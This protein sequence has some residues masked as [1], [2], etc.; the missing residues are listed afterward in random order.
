V[1]FRNMSKN[2]PLKKPTDNKAAKGILF[3]RVSKNNRCI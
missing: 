3:G 2:N 1:V